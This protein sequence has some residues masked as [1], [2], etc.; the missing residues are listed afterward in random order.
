VEDLEKRLRD[1]GIADPRGRD[2]QD[3]HNFERVIGTSDEIKV[4]ITSDDMRFCSPFL[5]HLFSITFFDH[6]FNITPSEPQ[7]A[8]HP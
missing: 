6:L 8:V 7:L 3:L 4:I 2:D 1:N 5:D